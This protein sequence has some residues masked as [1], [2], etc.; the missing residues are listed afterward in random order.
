M[1]ASVVDK[2][3]RVGLLWV[4][5]AC[6]GEDPAAVRTKGASDAVAGDATGDVASGPDV[7]ADGLS[8]TGERRRSSACLRHRCGMRQHRPR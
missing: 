3:V 8:D 6:C 1:G 4:W 2:R 5:V 7:T